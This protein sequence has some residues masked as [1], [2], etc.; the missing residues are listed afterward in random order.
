MGIVKK[1]LS[2]AILAVIIPQ[3]ASAASMV[4]EV[5]ANPHVWNG[6]TGY[7]GNLGLN[8]GINLNSGD[9]L[10]VDVNDITDTW[11]ICPPSSTCIVDAGGVR[12]ALGTTYGTYSNS[13]SS[14]AYGSLVGRVGSGDF[15][16]VGTRGFS[17]FADA[18]G[19]LS[20]FH[21]D[22]NVNNGGSLTVTVNYDISPVP[23]PAGLPLLLGAL[24]L[25]G[26]AARRRKTKR[27]VN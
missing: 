12:P 13:G 5:E 24:G 14:F 3:F 10:T 8:T 18:T 22:H 26:A 20:L 27:S 7:G 23:L 2:S 17:G 19:A 11:L 15:F 25:M 16:N 4:F 21:W 1:L 9:A 6:G